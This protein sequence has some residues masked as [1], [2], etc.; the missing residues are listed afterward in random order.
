MTVQEC[1]FRSVFPIQV[2]ADGRAVREGLSVDTGDHYITAVSIPFD[3]TPVEIGLRAA[4]WRDQVHKWKSCGLRAADFILLNRRDFGFEASECRDSLWDSKHNLDVKKG[5]TVVLAYE[6]RTSDQK[7]E[8]TVAP[9]GGQ[10]VQ[11]QSFARRVLAPLLFFPVRK[12]SEEYVVSFPE[13]YRRQIQ[14]KLCRGKR[15]KE[16]VSPKGNP[17][18]IVPSKACPPSHKKS[19]SKIRSVVDDRTNDDS[20]VFSL[21]KNL[22]PPGGLPPHPSLPERLPPP[23]WQPPRGKKCSGVYDVFG[24]KIAD[25]FATGHPAH[26]RFKSISF[27]EGGYWLPEPLDSYV[28]FE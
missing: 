24:R 10:A 21:D 3:N 16:E 12:D 8:V 26:F 7:V 1:R 4:G 15:K 6:G 20:G 22:E 13:Q 28:R 18:K 14:V 27:P 5:E 11:K 2:F 25:C 19:C 23:S 17:Y 9:S